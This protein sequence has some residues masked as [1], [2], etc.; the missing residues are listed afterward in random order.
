VNDVL[1]FGSP[2]PIEIAVIGGKNAG[3][4]RAYVERMRTNLAKIPEVRDLQYAQSLDYPTV[5]VNVD[6]RK[7]AYSGVLVSEVA[8]S[9]IPATSSSRFTM[10]N[11]WPD[12][13]TGVGYQVQVQVPQRVVTEL[14][15]IETIPI[16]SDGETQV[17]LRDVAEI[18]R[19]VMPG[20]YD[21]YNNKREIGLTANIS[22]TDLH[23]AAGDVRRA[24][25]DAGKVPE[26]ATLDIRGQIPTMEQLLAGLGVGLAVAV[27]VIFLL[28]AANF[29][30]WR[31]ALAA[32]STAPATATGVVLLL[33]LTHTTLNLQSFIGAIM[34]IG[35]SMA[36][37][38]LL[39]TFAEDSRRAGNEAQ[40]AAVTGAAARLRPILMTTCAMIAGMLP[41]A[42]GLGESGQQ[43]AP[44]G[45]AVVGGLV[46]S[47]AATLFILPSLYALIQRRATLRSASLDPEDPH[48]VY[49]QHAD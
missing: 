12:P 36:N 10:P 43:V 2:T 47:T 45:R 16:K 37:S 40:D 13:K 14:E 3:D 19:G 48:S 29:Q 31:L 17:L 39:V 4:V 33:W 28:L 6:R 11:Y 35:V 42:L 22:G 46:G 8:R 7:A 32:V 49:F 44:L 41:M 23:T 34:A 9:L 30:S 21:R 1:S 27:V 15:D 5:E 18:T 20:Q 26:G 38:I 25:A 24:L